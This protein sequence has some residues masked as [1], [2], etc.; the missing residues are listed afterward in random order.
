MS[1]L[2]VAPKVPPDWRDWINEFPTIKAIALTCVLAWIITPIVMTVA[3]WLIGSGFTTGATAIDGVLKMISTW[4]DALNW[5]TLAAVFGVV[6]KRATEKPELV[7]AE[8]EA[9]A[10]Q[11]VAAAQADAV[12]KTAEWQA[13]PATQP[14]SG[15]TVPP[16]AAAHAFDPGA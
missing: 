5:L 16:I 12:K 2:E 11:T 10:A 8:G 1:E 13:P 14:S 7:R 3:G 9:K 4:L 15:L 6:G